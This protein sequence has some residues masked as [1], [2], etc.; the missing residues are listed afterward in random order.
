M[1]GSIKDPLLCI[2]RGGFKNTVIGIWR[3]NHNPEVSM[4]KERN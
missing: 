1:T 3:K 2:E 4:E